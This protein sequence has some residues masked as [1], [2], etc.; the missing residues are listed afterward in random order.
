MAKRFSRE[1]ESKDLENLFELLGPGPMV[2][3]VG[4]EI[5]HLVP[6]SQSEDEPSMR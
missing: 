6:G 4:H 2:H 1:A 3:A 5:R